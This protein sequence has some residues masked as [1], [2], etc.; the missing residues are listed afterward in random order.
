MPIG[1]IIKATDE[2]A[3][4]KLQ[5]KINELLLTKS[6][7]KQIN[8]HYR[9]YKNL[10]DCEEIDTEELSLTIAK[11]L[12]LFKKP[13]PQCDFIKLTSAITSYRKRLNDLNELKFTSDLK[14][15]TILKAHTGAE[16]NQTIEIL[17]K[18]YLSL[19]WAINEH[20]TLFE[21]IV[22]RKN[23]RIQIFFDGPVK[24]ELSKLMFSYGFKYS[25][26][27]KLWQRQLTKAGLEKTNE[28]LEKLTGKL[29]DSCK[30]NQ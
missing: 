23:F 11:N 13:F 29:T 20:Q 18:G 12:E 17:E 19:I 2:H 27:Q 6:K 8:K 16:T 24:K 7:M 30:N 1:Q 9:E 22:N 25:P 5:A 10:D 28:L 21:A 4:E 14:P 26:T 15:T 3:D